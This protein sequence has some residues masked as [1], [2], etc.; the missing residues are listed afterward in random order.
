MDAEYFVHESAGGACY[1]SSSV[2]LRG[3]EKVII[4]I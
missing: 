3:F 2:D 4:G 1:S